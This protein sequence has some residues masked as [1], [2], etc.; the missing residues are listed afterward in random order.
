MDSR[1]AS[2]LLLF[3]SLL[4]WVF[5]VVVLARDDSMGSYGRSSVGVY[6]PHGR[7][8]CSGW[9]STRQ[10]V[11]AFDTMA[12][13]LMGITM[14]MH[15]LQGAGQGGLIP[16]AVTPHIKHIHLVSALFCLIG[17][18]LMIVYVEAEFCTH[19]Q[20]AGSPTYGPFFVIICM[21]FEIA[22]YFLCGMGGG[23][24]GSGCQP[25]MA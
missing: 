21:L 9:D 15:M 18:I 6:Q 16:Y 2:I 19:W 23:S 4:G 14:I 13:V 1:S 25:L 7:T 3:L 17:W 22:A 5:M 12:C 24:G 11:Q 8:G 20:Y 10:A